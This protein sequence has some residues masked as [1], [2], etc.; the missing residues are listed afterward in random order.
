MKFLIASAV[1]LFTSVTV[2]GAATTTPLYELSFDAELISKKYHIE[3]EGHWFLYE[4]PGAHSISGGDLAESYVPPN[5]GQTWSSTVTLSL[6]EEDG[7]SDIEADC[8]APVPC[9]G[10]GQ[11]SGRFDDGLPDWFCQQPSFVPDGLRLDD[12]NDRL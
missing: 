1:A 10:F 6:Y 3:E 5:I 4:P 8:S 7:Y 12:G 11:V 9:Y 2:V